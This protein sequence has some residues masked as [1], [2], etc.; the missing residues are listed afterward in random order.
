[1]LASKSVWRISYLFYNLAKLYF[2]VLV[3]ETEIGEMVISEMVIGEMVMGEMV[4]GEMV[5]GE[6]VMG[7]MVMGEMV[8]GEMVISELVLGEMV[9]GE[10]AWNPSSQSTQKSLESDLEMSGLFFHHRCNIMYMFVV[11]GQHSIPE[12]G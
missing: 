7:E 2:I 9:I 12:P 6:M 5:M 1:M 10:I 3:S 11:L 4:M 8:I